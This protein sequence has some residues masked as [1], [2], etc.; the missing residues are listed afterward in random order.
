MATGGEIGWPPAGR[1]D[2]HQW[3]IKGRSGEK[4]TDRKSRPTS[5]TTS[6]VVAERKDQ[7]TPATQRSWTV[8]C[9]EE[10]RV[11]ARTPGTRSEIV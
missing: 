8:R 4:R 5:R 3:G 2:G 9:G 7:R 1:N 6:M 11:R 10:L